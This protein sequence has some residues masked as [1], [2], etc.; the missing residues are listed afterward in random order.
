MSDPRRILKRA[1]E[2]RV[3]VDF[4]PKGGTR[5]TGTIISVEHGSIVASL[6]DRN[7]FSGVE[8]KCWFKVDGKE[9]SFEASVIRTGVP[10]PNR[11]QNGVMFGYIDQWR[12]GAQDTSLQIEVL[13]PNGPAL[14]IDKKP[15]RLVELSL[16]ELTFVVPSNF[17][18]V[19]AHQG[20]VNL[21]MRSDQRTVLLKARVKDLIQKEGVVFYVFSFEAVD[22]SDRLREF[23]AMGLNSTH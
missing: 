5:T 4:L 20:A 1:S 17:P 18:L 11:S 7:V 6:E 12:Q 8:I 21:R 9:Y 16:K 19:F 23:V 10:V 13:L 14:R 2:Q 3:S 22:D 15:S